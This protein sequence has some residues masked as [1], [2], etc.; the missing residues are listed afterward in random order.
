LN[1]IKGLDV[2]LEVVPNLLYGESVTVAGLLSGKCLYSS[3]KSVD[4]GDLILLPPD[5]LNADGLFLDDMTVHQLAERLATPVMVFEGD[6]KAV[7][8]RLMNP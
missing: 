4:K 7:F 6:W 2:G 5:I 1:T 8:T 3:L